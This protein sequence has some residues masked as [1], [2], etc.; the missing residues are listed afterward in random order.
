MKGAIIPAGL[1]W[2][3]RQGTRAIAAI[4]LVGI[5]FP[6]VGE[7][8]KSYVAEAIFLL[9]CIAFMRVDMTAAR[10]CLRRPGLVFA[11]TAWMSLAVPVILG[12]ICLVSGVDSIAPAL[13]VA[14]M[15]QAVASPIMAAPSLAVLMGLD[16]TLVLITL[17]C[18]TAI[19]PLTAPL[20][21][22]LFVGAAL[23]ISPLLLAGKLG[24]IL[25]GAACAGFVLR[26]Y[27][28]VHAIEKH[29]EKIDGL[30]LI[31]LFIFV[32]AIME[33]VAVRLLSDPVMVIG[34]TLLS[35]VIF[36]AVLL[37]TTFV[38]LPFGRKQ[39]LSIGFTA[40]QRNMG[41]MLA[42][43][44]GEMSEVTWL[45]F[46]LAQFP[47]FLAPCMLQTLVQKNI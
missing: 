39:A 9:L 1:S 22:E 7:Y 25:V 31:I 17:V 14:I 42:A 4:V 37:L 28:G 23:S 32:A 29:K 20:F 12:A 18:S 33:N 43:A 35:F 24:I 45:Y 13:F 44:G 47:I 36:F 21:A 16:A 19:V 41:L 46:A 38:F 6:W 34:F 15:L 26:C 3:G 27:F 30:N 8:L 2:L 11:A 40:S 5:C 10:A